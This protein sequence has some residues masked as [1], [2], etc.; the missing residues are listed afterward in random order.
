MSYH[1]FEADDGTKCG[2]FETFYKG[3]DTP[4]GKECGAGWYWW[5]CFPGCMPDGDPMG[6]FESE[7][8]AYLNAQVEG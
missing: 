6:P 2:S 3:A 7:A 1:R 5:A 8:A 4:L